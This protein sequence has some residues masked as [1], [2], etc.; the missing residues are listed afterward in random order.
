[1]SFHMAFK[2]GYIGPGI[3][4]I[5]FLLFQITPPAPHSRNQTQVST[6][7]AGDLPMKPTPG[8]V[9]VFDS[10][11]F[12]ISYAFPS[13]LFIAINSYSHIV[14]LISLKVSSQ[15]RDTMLLDNNKDFFFMNAHNMSDTVNLYRILLQIDTVLSE[16]TRSWP[17]QILKG[18]EQML[19]IR[20]KLIPAWSPR[21]HQECPLSNDPTNLS[22]AGRRVAGQ[23]G[24]G[25]RRQ[26]NKQKP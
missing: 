17:G 20:L 2:I 19:C 25:G 22:T 8:L 24:V 1:M 18:L 3:Y 14:I 13:W 12:K 4:A 23:W 9:F 26:T 5:L 7:K 21:H 11:C 6:G 16:K 10:V 15:R